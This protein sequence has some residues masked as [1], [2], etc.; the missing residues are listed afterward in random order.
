[1]AR[2]RSAFRH[3]LWEA[4]RILGWIPVGIVFTRHI[5]SVASV[6]GASMQ[7]TFN[8]DLT[9]NPL[10]HDVVLLER[11]SIELS[12]FQRGDVVTLW[13]PQD[14]ELL[15]TKRLVALEG[16]LVNPLPPSLPMP[17][18]IPPGHCWVEGDSHL[19]TRDSN[20]Y[21]PV[22]IRLKHCILRSAYIQQ[23]PLAL[24]TARSPRGVVFAP[25]VWLI[26]EQLGHAALAVILVICR[27]FAAATQPR[28]SLSSLLKHEF[29]ALWYAGFAGHSLRHFY[30]IRQI[31]AVSHG[32]HML[33]AGAN[34]HPTGDQGVIGVYQMTRTVIEYEYAQRPRSMSGGESVH[35]FVL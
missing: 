28:A 1:M 18:R 35:R 13:S 27:L 10:H 11:W 15:T 26:A 7:P 9:L 25:E 32:R 4:V 8:P 2:A 6:T 23:I 34:V 29:H 24:I 30:A 20:T 5:Y 31:P 17:V 16:D 12:R 3:N 14:P 21:G 19:H 33:S 22:R